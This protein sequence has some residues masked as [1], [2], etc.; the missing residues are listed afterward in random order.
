[1]DKY[2]SAMIIDGTHNDPTIIS[3]DNARIVFD[4]DKEGNP[5]LTNSILIRELLKQLRKKK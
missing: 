4:F 2:I 5:I 3:L 1:M